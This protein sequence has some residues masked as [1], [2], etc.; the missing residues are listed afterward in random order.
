LAQ[1]TRGSSS[2]QVLG[3][4]EDGRILYLTDAP[5]KSVW[6]VSL[7]GAAPKRL[8]IDARGMHAISYA[9]GQ[10]WL[11]YM[12]GPVPN[13][14][15]VNLDGTDRRQLTQTGFD[16]FPRVVPGGAEILYEHWSAGGP[17]IWKVPSSGGQAVRL[18]ERASARPLALSPDGNRFWAWIRGDSTNEPGKLGIFRVSD[19]ALER[20]IDDSRATTWAANQLGQ[21]S[22]DG[23]SMIFRRS[24]GN[25]GNLWSG[26]LDGGEPLQVTQFQADSIY[27]FAFSPDGQRIAMSRGTT[28]GDI[29]LIK[30]YR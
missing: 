21:W 19:G 8:P 11:A 28:T 22:H 18:L 10:K 9:P 13:I 7:D 4:T 12:A 3:W 6:S 25:I 30:D 23:V 16:R 20:T 29:V 1:L 26:R 14:W 15:R 24:P 5:E 2:D 27:S 17:S